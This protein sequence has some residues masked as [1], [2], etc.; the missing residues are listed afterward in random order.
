[1]P[2]SALRRRGLA[3]FEQSLMKLEEIVAQLERGDL[4]LEDSVRLFEEGTQLAAECRKQ[5]EEAEGKVE[6]LVKERDGAMKRQPF[7]P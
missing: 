2:G 4:S 5:L 3:G 6:M 1:M 7:G